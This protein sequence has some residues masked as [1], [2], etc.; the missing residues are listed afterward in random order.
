M[1][2]TLFVAGLAINLSLKSGSDDGQRD[3]NV[4]ACR[5]GIGADRMG[6]FGEGLNLGL[7]GARNRNLEIDL[8]AEAG[9]ILVEG[10]GAGHP[11]IGAVEAVFLAEKDNRLAITGR[12]AQRKKL[13]R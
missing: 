1:R 6:V 10:D 7:V 11:R 8:E 5:L 2:P 4:A 13:F 9:G 12:I 3:G